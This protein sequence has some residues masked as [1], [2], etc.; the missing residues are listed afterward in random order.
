M[1]CEDDC[2][3]FIDEDLGTTIF[4]SILRSAELKLEILL[5]HFPPGTRDMDWIPSVALK[6]WVIVTHDRDIR[7]R[8]PERDAIMRNNGRAIVIRVNG[9]RAE[10]AQIF[11]NLR[12]QIIEF[13]RQNPAPFIARLYRDRIEMWLSRDDWTP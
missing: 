13:L 4:P 1:N 2:V 3:F 8:R 10:M 7:Y 6:D 9:T 5:E 11:L 12:E